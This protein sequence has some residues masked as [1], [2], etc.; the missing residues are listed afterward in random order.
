MKSF[1]CSLALFLSATGLQAQDLIVGLTQDSPGT[2]NIT[3]AGKP[4]ATYVI[5]QANKPY[6]WPVY[7][8]TGKAMTRAF[9][10]A[11][12][13]GEQKDH[14]HHRGITFGHESSGGA[15][16]RFPAKWDGLNGS[17]VYHGGADT[18]HERRTFEEFMENPKSELMGRCRLPILGKIQHKEFTRLEAAGDHAVIAEVCEYLD[19]QGK[20]FYT[21]E[22]QLTFRATA[23]QRIIDMDQDFLASDEPVRFEDRKDSGLSIRVPTSMAVDSKLGGHIVTSA[24]KKDQEAWGQPAEWCDYYGPV[25]GATLGVAMLNHPASYR[26]PTRW[27]VRTYGLFTANPFALGQYDKKLGD[28]TTELKAGERLKLRHRIVLHTGDATSADIAG[29]FAAYAK[30]SK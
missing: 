19:A 11:E 27:H 10:M 23:T 22:R 15:D 13:A 1:L 4:F 8:P 25:E 17:E 3:V 9:P 18:W 12:V 29:A 14:P 30:E 16:W 5:D 24:G 2:V 28:G 20:R 26:Y 6:L 21:E 7:G